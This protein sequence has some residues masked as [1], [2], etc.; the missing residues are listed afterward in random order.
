MNGN[1]FMKWITTKVILLITCNYTGVQM[2][3]VMENAP[4]HHVRG[5][6][7]LTIFSKKSTVNLMKEHV[8]NYVLLLLTNERISILPEQYNRTINN[9]H[10]QLILTN[11]TYRK[12]NQIKR[13]Q[14]SIIRRTKGRHFGWSTTSPKSFAT[15]WRRQSRI[16][17]LRSFGRHP[18]A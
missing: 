7:Y 13:S 9:G 2:V 3:P 12:E 18:T 5:I 6:P 11:N 8:I 17:A 4:Y 10:L 16:L 15:E 1:M 14:N